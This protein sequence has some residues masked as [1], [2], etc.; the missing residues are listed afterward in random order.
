M[1]LMTTA[2]PPSFLSLPSKPSIFPYLRQ[3]VIKLANTKEEAVVGLLWSFP[4][5]NW[6]GGGT[7]D[8]NPSIPSLL[9]SHPIFFT[10]IHNVF[11]HLV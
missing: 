9:F 5:L 10:E 3:I 6:Q 4:V 8:L 1:R 2:F 11:L 7:L